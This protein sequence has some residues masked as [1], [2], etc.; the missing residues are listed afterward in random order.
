MVEEPKRQF[1]PV[2]FVLRLVASIG[3]GLAL[4]AIWWQYSDKLLQQFLPSFLGG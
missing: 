3:V 4:A 2:R 1:K